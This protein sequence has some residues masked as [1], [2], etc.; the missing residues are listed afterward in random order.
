MN[1]D[2]VVDLRKI[3]LYYA[4]TSAL[5]LMLSSQFTGFIMPLVF[6][7]PIYMG[8]MA[9]KARRKSGYL[10]G[11]AIVPLA[12]AISVLWIRYSLSIFAD[13]ANQI[14]KMSAELSMSSTAAQVIIISFF[15]LSIIMIGTSVMLFVNLRRHKE[16][17]T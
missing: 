14:A 15:T 2:E 13:R 4:I 7:I 5:F 17:F 1:I 3:T 10:I 9:I 6:I 16:L 11:M 12:F 8:L